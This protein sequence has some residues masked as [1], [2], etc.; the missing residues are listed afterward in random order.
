MPE[1][2]DVEGFRRYLARHAAGR[3]IERVE[4]RDATLLRNTTPQGLGH[5]VRG[6]RFGEPR[7]HGKGLFAD[8]GAATVA[9]HFGMTG[10][11]HWTADAGYSH[12]HD[13]VVFRLDGGQLAYRNMRKFGGVWLARGEAEL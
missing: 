5:A 1:L 9:M 7:R 8:A 2:S 6:E 13:R 12:Q 11:L 3:R 10:L 4:V